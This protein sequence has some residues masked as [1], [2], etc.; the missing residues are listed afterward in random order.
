MC[1]S[2]SSLLFS[3]NMHYPPL[4]EN[5]RLQQLLIVAGT[6][7]ISIP[8]IWKLMKYGCYFEMWIG[9]STAFVS[10][11]YHSAE[12][13]RQPILG[14][15][16]GQWHR[17]DNV[18][19]IMSFVS[20]ILWLM[21]N[22]PRTDEFLRWMFMAIV[23][24]GQEKGPW[25][26]TYTITPIVAVS[27]LF[28]AKYVFQRRLPDYLKNKSDLKIFMK[29]IFFLCIAIYFF[30]KGLDERS[31][32]LRIKHGMWHFFAGISFFIFFDLPVSSK[33]TS[34][35]AP[36]E[37]QK[38]EYASQDL[39]SFFGCSTDRKTPALSI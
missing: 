13:L 21:D 28:V 1:L 6:N 20:L 38:Q 17:L 3:R 31:D 29:A 39:K 32:Y 2:F 16:D 24:W 25:D 4:T 11:M 10:V 19:A 34:I 35:R 27:L 9:I 7:A 22:N 12:A 36:M 8:A 14:M 23:T 30:V 15:N 26:L 33:L 18:F 37:H 5:E